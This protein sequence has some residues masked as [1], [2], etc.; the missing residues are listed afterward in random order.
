M[1]YGIHSCFKFSIVFAL[2]RV[3][4]IVLVVVPC[5]HLPYGR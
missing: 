2:A 3:A 4:L 1:K 5:P